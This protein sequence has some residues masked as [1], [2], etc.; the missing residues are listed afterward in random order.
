MQCDHSAFKVG[1]HPLGVR[2]HHNDAGLPPSSWQPC[3]ALLW[4]AAEAAKSLRI[5]QRKL[6]GLTK[7]GL[8]PAVRIGRAVR[9]SPVDLRD[10]IDRLKAEVAEASLSATA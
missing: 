3:G 8:I 5:S 9:Y 1:G 2:Q 7:R 6:W 10:Y 4:T